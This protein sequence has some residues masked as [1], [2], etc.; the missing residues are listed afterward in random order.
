M[1]TLLLLSS[2]WCVARAML[3]LRA[4]RKD[5]AIRWLAA[6][7][8]GG[9]AFAVS[10]ALEYAVKITAGHNPSAGEFL[11]YYYVL[12]GIHLLHV[13]VGCILLA[14][15]W[16]RWRRGRIPGRFAGFES[17]ACYWH[18]RLPLDRHLPAVPRQI[19]TLATDVHVERAGK[20][21]WGRLDHPWPRR[22]RRLRSGGT[23]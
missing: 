4:N 22:T 13:V 8:A 5:A 7:I 20:P 10:K 2:S 16:L 23:R 14:V 17:A 11:M 6:G 21:S 19:G 9:T 18:G 1:N 15:S 12:T 3:A